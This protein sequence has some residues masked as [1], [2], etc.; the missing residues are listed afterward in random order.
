VFRNLELKRTS[1]E[2]DLKILNVEYLSNHWPDLILILMPK[3][4]F[5]MGLL[6]VETTLV[7]LLAWSLV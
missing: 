5:S 2:D 7:S 1:M 3:V 4:V 6:W